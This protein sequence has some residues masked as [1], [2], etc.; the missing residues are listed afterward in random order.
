MATVYLDTD[1]KMWNDYK[2]WIMRHE[3]KMSAKDCQKL[4]KLIDILHNCDFFPPTPNDK[5]RA[6]DGLELR[7]LY[8]DYVDADMKFHRNPK[9]LEVLAALS[10][11]MEDEYVGDPSDPRPYIIFGDII[12]LNLDLSIK[13]RESDVIGRLTAWMDGDIPLF[14]TQK[15]PAKDDIWSQMQVYIHE[16]Y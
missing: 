13:M 2:V 4:S 5:N 9:V 11:R 1:K 7:V 14:K 15:K 8:L 12:Q 6:E 3:L 10:C 16:N